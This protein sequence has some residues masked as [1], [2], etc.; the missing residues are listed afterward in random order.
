MYFHRSRVCKITRIRGFASFVGPKSVSVDGAVY[1]ANHILVAVG[2][3][4]SK[5]GVPGDVGGYYWYVLNSLKL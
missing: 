5:L 1:S 2:G 3:T 4:P